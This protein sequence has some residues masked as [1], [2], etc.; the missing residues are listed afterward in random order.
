M[1][2]RSNLSEGHIILGPAI[3]TLSISHH[4][5]D[6]KLGLKIQNISSEIVKE[7]IESI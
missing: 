3:C 5:I 2:N 4:K 6:I 1:Y 7:K